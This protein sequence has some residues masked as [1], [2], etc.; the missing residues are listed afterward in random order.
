MK[1]SIPIDEN[2]A[3]L[4]ELGIANKAFQ[5]IYPGDRPDR[6][7]VHTVYGGADLFKA[8]LA[9]KMGKA[10]LNTLL[11]NACNFVE[12]AKAIELDGHEQ[13]PN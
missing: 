11:S 8:D 6:Q 4:N 13:L 1:F 5:N 9:E 7:P 2:K 3:I 12:F 10:A